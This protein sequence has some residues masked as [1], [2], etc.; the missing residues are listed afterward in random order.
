VIVGLIPVSTPEALWFI[1]IS[2]FVAICAMILPG[3]SGAFLLLILGK[4]EFITGTLKNPFNLDNIIVIFV[5][6]CGCFGGLLSFSRLLN[7]LLTKWHTLTLAFLTGLMGG[8]MRKIWPWK[9]VLEKQVIRGKEHIISTRNIFPE[10]FNTE[11]MTA[12]GLAGIGFALVIIL[13]RLSRE[14]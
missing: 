7:Y 12:I 2:G 1:F 13:E 4:Y 9:E 5:F 14:E 10:A 3:L 11:V 6:C 8:S